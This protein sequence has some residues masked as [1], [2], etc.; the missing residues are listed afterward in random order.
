MH[1]RLLDKPD[2]AI[3]HV[4]FDAPGEKLLVEA[5]AMIAR[6]PGLELK[7]ELRGGLLSA[8]KRKLLGGESL[9]QNTFIAT[10]PG[11]TLWIAPG[12]QGDVEALELR[13]DTEVFLQSGAFLA[14]AP[15]VT[16]D[17]KWEGARGFFS[18]NG[19]FLLRCGGTG[20]LFFNAY[21]GLHAV[22]V[23]PGGYI[24]D[25]SHI[26]GFTAGLDYR[27]R[28][29][30]GMKSLFFS[31]EGLVC[32]FRGQGRLWLSTRNPHNLAAFLHPY[33]RVSRND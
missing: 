24:V 33:R 9:F 20:P 7:T 26:V 11:Q 18:G 27:V 32:E 4:T 30:G 2:F 1:H 5:E 3:V 23:G 22:D 10:A 31:G 29:V 6:D 8:A 15:S 19:L 28:K 14:A 17:T 13:G 12:P 25:T 21:G 16:L